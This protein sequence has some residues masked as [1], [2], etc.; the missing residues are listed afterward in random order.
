MG[1]PDETQAS[2]PPNS[3]IICP[4]HE[5]PDYEDHHQ[6]VK[7]AWGKELFGIEHLQH[8]MEKTSSICVDSIVRLIIM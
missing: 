4:R 2:N 5:L 3:C 6:C 1:F 8:N 7:G